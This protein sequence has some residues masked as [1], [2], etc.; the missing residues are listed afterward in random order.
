MHIR[1]HTPTDFD[2][3]AE[4]RWLLKSEDDEAADDGRNRM[5]VSRYIGQLK[6]SESV[7]DTVHWVVDEDG[8][9]VG[10]MTVRLVRKELSLSTEQDFWGYLTNSFVRSSR[11]NMGVGTDLLRQTIEWAGDAGLKF[12]IVWPSAA[13]YPFYR[14]A[15]FV[16]REDPLQLS[17]PVAHS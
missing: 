10:V 1:R 6:T 5:F 17:L 7:G 13:S 15:G 16:G 9:L 2:Q 4:L 12:L 14:R 3:I 11:R 8:T